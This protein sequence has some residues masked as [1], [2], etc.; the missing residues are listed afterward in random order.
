M[1][2]D[3]GDTADSNSSYVWTVQIMIRYMGP[4]RVGTKRGQCETSPWRSLTA[5]A[6]YG[7]QH[8]CRF[9]ETTGTPRIGTV[10]LDLNFN[11]LQRVEF[12]QLELTT[13]EG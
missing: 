1:H 3:T 2:I 8:E 12:G 11:V 7:L 9:L 10:S 6:L 5:K 13:V 4:G